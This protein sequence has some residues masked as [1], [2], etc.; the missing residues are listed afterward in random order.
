MWILDKI[1][2]FRLLPKWQRVA[3]GTGIAMVIFLLASLLPLSA[4]CVYVIEHF[5][6]RT[7]L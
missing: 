2:E 5:L 1:D 6:E 3:L 4:E 7:G